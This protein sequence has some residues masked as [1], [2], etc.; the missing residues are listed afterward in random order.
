MLS[1][2]SYFNSFSLIRPLRTSSFCITKSFSER[3][4]HTL[5]TL[6]PE[7]YLPSERKASKQITKAI[8]LSQDVKSMNDAIKEKDLIS[9]EK[10]LAKQG[11]A[12]EEQLPA[13]VAY[14]YS[15]ELDNIDILAKLKASQ[16]YDFSKECYLDK[17]NPTKL[18]SAN[19]FLW[20]KVVESRMRRTELERIVEKLSDIYHYPKEEEKL[21]EAKKDL[22]YWRLVE[23]HSDCLHQLFTENDRKEKN[24]RLAEAIVSCFQSE[25]SQSK[26]A[27]I[28]RNDLFY[29]SPSSRMVCLLAE[30]GPGRSNPEDCMRAFVIGK[31]SQLPEDLSDKEFLRQSAFEYFKN[32][33]YKDRAMTYFN[34]SLNKENFWEDMDEA[35][36]KLNIAI[37]NKEKLLE[38]DAQLRM[39]LSIFNQSIKFYHYRLPIDSL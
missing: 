35:I 12:G 38:A 28:V 9:I 15:E 25:S 27:E 13:S 24:R 6:C 1:E 3:K 39:V 10:N 5:A 19:D 22:I 34:Q 26:A 31:V 7:F 8:C 23:K 18:K 14:R 20:K 16:K 29:K 17:E 37:K 4:C 11:P 30:R 21:Q 32:V 2:L 33:P 36:A